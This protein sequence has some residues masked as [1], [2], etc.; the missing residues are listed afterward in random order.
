VGIA[1]Q[2]SP[3][4]W[5]QRVTKL[6][7]R[8]DL[9]PD[10]PVGTFVSPIRWRVL[11]IQGQVPPDITSLQQQAYGP[12]GARLDIPAQ[13]ANGAPFPILHDEWLD[14]GLGAPGLNQ[15]F[16]REFTD[17]GPAADPNAY[18]SAILCPLIDKA[19]PLTAPNAAPFPSAQMTLELWGTSATAAAFGG[20]PST[21]QAGQA[22]LPRYDNA[23]SR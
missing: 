22:S 10:V 23:K 2:V 20:S 21:A 19:Y 3:A 6:G 11:V 8:V 12:A 1:I 14:F 18:M 13:L 5:A 15:L 16:L 7:W 17:G 9:A 4:A